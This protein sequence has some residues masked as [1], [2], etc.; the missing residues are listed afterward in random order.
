MEIE[1]LKREDLSSVQELA[2][3]CIRESYQTFF[4]QEMID[5]YIN[6][7]EADREISNYADNCYVLMEKHKLIGY[8]VFYDNFIHIMMIDPE[9]QGKGYGTRL[10]AFAELSMLTKGH[11][12]LKLETF[13][14]NK[15]AISFYEKNN[16]KI[17]HQK[18]EEE[19]DVTKVFLEKQY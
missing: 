9:F 12:I 7:G 6:S 18:R 14:E 16:W 15:Q 8:N 13:L 17:S 5:W 3:R 4:S 19:L 11:P 1:K 2:K 10:L